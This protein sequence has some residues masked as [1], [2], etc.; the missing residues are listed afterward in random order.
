M[1]RTFAFANSICEQIVSDLQ[2]RG[3]EMHLK[4]ATNPIEIQLPGSKCPIVV[5]LVEGCGE[6]APFASSDDML[7]DLAHDAAI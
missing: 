5:L 3:E 4:D 7:L 6:Y 1:S 2:K